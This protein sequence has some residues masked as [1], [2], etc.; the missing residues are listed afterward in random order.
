MDSGKP[1]RSFPME[2]ADRERVSPLFLLTAKSVLYVANSSLKP[3]ELDYVAT[4]EKIAKEEGASFIILDC[5]LESE[6]AQLPVEERAEY[7][8][9]LGLSEPG[10]NRFI[11]AA[12]DL[13]GLITYYT[14]GVKE[15]RAWTSHKGSRAPQA[16]GVIHTDFEKGFICA[17][18][19]KS[20]DLIRLGTE[21]K[22][23]EAGLSRQEG[24]EYVVQTGDV[25]LFRF[26]V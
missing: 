5:S 21:A 26:N 19:Y 3:N 12:F 15:A 25:M 4:V 14:A 2:P 6:I 9:G 24:K 11:R 13:L 22:I 10:L 1:V 7:L 8:S 16:A 18:C 17:E 20:D 23:K